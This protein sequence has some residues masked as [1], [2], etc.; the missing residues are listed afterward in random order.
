MR[1]IT[2]FLFAAL[3]SSQAFS[4][5]DSAES[6]ARNPRA[7]AIS[8][9]VGMN[10]LAS[11]IGPVATWYVQP[12]VAMDF[13][14]GLSGVGW[15]PG[16]RTRYLFSNEKLS[17]SGGL[18]FK[19]GLGTGG[20]Y[21]EVE[22]PDTKAKINVKIEPCAFLD[23]SLGLDYMAGNGFLV[24]ANAGYSSLLGGKNYVVKSGETASD[25]AE[26]VFDL[27]FGSGIMLSVSLGKAF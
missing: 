25:K 16:L 3:F 8:G 14:M 17:Y 7:W 20:K 24:I 10:S 6:E 5:T 23:L 22:D 9:E 11:L 15:R 19:Y 2:G 21:A 13:A 27:A 26:K 18:G 12:R 1:I 4:Q